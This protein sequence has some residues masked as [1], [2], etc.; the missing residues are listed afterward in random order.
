MPT[1]FEIARH[2]SIFFRRENVL[3]QEWLAQKELEASGGNIGESFE[4]YRDAL[5]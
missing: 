1:L 5:Y 4:K 2:S 3:L